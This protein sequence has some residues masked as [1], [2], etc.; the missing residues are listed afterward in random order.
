MCTPK[1]PNTVYDD[2]FVI[3]ATLQR[4]STEKFVSR[5]H[6]CCRLGCTYPPTSTQI[7]PQRQQRHRR[8][9]YKTTVASTTATI[10]I[11]ITKAT[12]TITTT[13]TKRHGRVAFTATSISVSTNAVVHSSSS[14]RHPQHWHS[15][16]NYWNPEH[17]ST[18][19]RGE[20]IRGSNC[21]CQSVQGKGTIP[22]GS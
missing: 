20:N 14:H 2:R 8:P 6:M 1:H 18:S 4:C 10:A 16:Q 5:Y 9:H 7:C 3:T 12:I 22:C 21:L 15:E 13:I 19:V 11:A 17:T